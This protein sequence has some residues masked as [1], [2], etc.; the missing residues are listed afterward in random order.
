MFKI[1][2]A[3]QIVENTQG[4]QLWTDTR[5]GQQY[6]Y[7]Q[8]GNQIWMIDNWNYGGLES[9]FR[10]I[11]SSMSSGHAWRYENVLDYQNWESEYGMKRGALYSDG[12]SYMGIPSGWH[13][14]TKAEWDAL[15]AW[16]QSEYVG[17]GIQALMA[18]TTFWCPNNPSSDVNFENYNK[19]GFNLVPAGHASWSNYNF[20]KSDKNY[21]CIASF[22][23]RSA[24]GYRRYYTFQQ[25]ENSLPT[26]EE[27]IFDSG[28][29]WASSVRL[30]KDGSIPAPQ[31]IITEITTSLDS[32][33]SDNKIATEKA[34]RT[35]ITNATSS[36]MSNPMTTAGDVIVGGSSGTPARLAIGTNGQVLTSNGTTASWA[37]VPAQDGDHKVATSS[38]DTTP[39]YL[40]DKI[41]AGNGIQL[42]E[43]VSGSSRYIEIEN[44][45]MEGDHQVQVSISDDSAGYLEDKI[46]AGTGIT[47]NVLSDSS[48]VETLEISSS[49]GG[50]GMVNPMTTANDIIIGGSSGTPTRLGAG[51]DK[52]ILTSNN[53]QVS[54]EDSLY[55]LGVDNTNDTYMF[56]TQFV[57]SNTR[58]GGGYENELKTLGMNS[59]SVGGILSLRAGTPVESGFIT[60]NEPYWRTETDVFN[61]GHPMTDQGDLIVGSASG[62]PMRFAAAGDGSFLKTTTVSGIGKVLQWAPLPAPS[63]QN[64]SLSLSDSTSESSSELENKVHFSKVFCPSAKTVSRM[65]F[66]HKSGTQGVVGMGIYDASGSALARTAVAGVTSS[67]QGHVCWMDLAS[68]I[69]LEAGTEYWFA[70]FEGWASGE[71]NC[72]INFARNTN[73]NGA[74]NTIII[75]YSLGSGTT[76]MPASISSTIEGQFTPWIVAD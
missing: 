12:T 21:N 5:D 53:G 76:S 60:Q 73:I 24:S 6:R 2:D 66:F 36:K 26:A 61:A 55:A 65:G 16:A 11:S 4:V 34:T 58:A 67:T 43:I 38:S 8:F 70:F 59:A 35:A 22:Y 71:W 49:G 25:D 56:Y 54:W 51:S 39:D 75:S 15:I 32:T 41:G 18:K 69:T 31:P 27:K 57:D 17:F 64:Y 68:S 10:P 30:I 47:I 52:Q 3:W 19:S 7:K 63:I 23:T 29:W 46:V 42:T 37:N 48:G 62:V 9:D 13:L 45:A 50:G 20:E 14:A 74:G 1:K 72:G 40:I 33:G 44:T 28:K